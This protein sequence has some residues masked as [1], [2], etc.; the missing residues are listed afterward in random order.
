MWN[1]LYSW[2]RHLYILCCLFI[3]PHASGSTSPPETKNGYQGKLNFLEK[4]E[5]TSTPISHHLDNCLFACIRRFWLSAA[6]IST[7]WVQISIFCRVLY[8]YSAASSTH[9][10]LVQLRLY[11][12][13]SI[14]RV[15][16]SLSS[17]I[18]LILPWK[19]CTCLQKFK[20]KFAIILC[21]H[22]AI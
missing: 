15:K 4:W 20:I 10:C 3:L 16:S 21:G 12:R 9:I 2:W 14:K 8:S 6:T 19:T 17:L 22:K 5:R 11:S 7:L 13:H 1:W 18:L